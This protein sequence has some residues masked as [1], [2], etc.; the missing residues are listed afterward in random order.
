MG[1]KNGAASAVFYK[2][3]APCK[4]G[5]RTNWRAAIAAIYKA[6]RCAATASLRCGPLWLARRTSLVCSAAG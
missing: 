3:S 5:G 1:G 4:P 2:C 6:L